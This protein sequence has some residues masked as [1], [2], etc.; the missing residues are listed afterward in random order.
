MR[1]LLTGA[2]GFLGGHLKARLERDGHTLSFLRRSENPRAFSTK[3]DAIINCAAELDEPSDMVQSNL[4]LV[5]QLLWIARAN[6][7]SKFIQIGSS[8]ETG[9]VEGPRS[10]ETHCQPSNLYEATKLAATHLCLGYALQYGMDVCVARPFSLYGPDDKPRKMLPALWR[11]FCSGSRFDCYAGGHDWI[12]VDDFVEGIV[13]LLAA[14]SEWTKG[15]VF[16]FGTGV[17]TSNVSIVHLFERAVGSQLN[18][19]YHPEKLRPYD[20]TDWRADN[21]LHIG[22]ITKV[23]ARTGWTPKISITE[24]ISSLVMD[25]WFFEE[26]STGL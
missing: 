13:K 25:K 15:E 11:A 10:E 23:C 22:Q 12:H 24:G 7:V 4:T 26:Q 18:V 9:P 17:C 14:P 5:E 8:S 16:H 21:A 2:S 3:W 20:V 19:V 1:I 6:E